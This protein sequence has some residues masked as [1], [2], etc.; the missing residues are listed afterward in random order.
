M[1]TSLDSTSFIS[2]PLEH[3]ESTN[4]IQ[5]ISFASPVLSEDAVAV[6][7][8]RVVTD[9]DAN[10]SGR[11][12]NVS[13]V[14]SITGQDFMNVSQISTKASASIVCGSNRHPAN[15]RYLFQYEISP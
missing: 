2:L 13:T 10:L 1:S 14:R 11:S 12:L 9:S 8:N 5:S 3:K 7:G 4:C 6:C 15:S